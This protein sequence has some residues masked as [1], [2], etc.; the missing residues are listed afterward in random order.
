[1]DDRLNTPT[2]PSEGSHEQPQELAPD[3]E[4]DQGPSPAIEASMRIPS[5]PL[6]EWA[7]PQPAKPVAAEASRKRTLR[8][9]LLI[10]LSLTLAAFVLTAWVLVRVD[11]PSRTFSTGPQEIVRAQ[12][13]ALDQGQL[14]PAY[15]MFSARYR[16][17]VTFDVW[18]E[19]I[20]THWRMFHA[21]VLRAG[22]PARSGPVVTL[23][24]HLRGSD[25][26]EYR[27]RFVLISLE[28]RW[29]ID[30]VH[31]AEEADEQN[32]VRI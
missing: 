17:Q 25:D 7:G 31:W 30:D 6:P 15:D 4:M 20:I 18:H 14:R 22:E 27:A 28:G 5:G 1:M 11:S 23:E 24:I 12:L 9:R 21:E 19:L 8:R 29:W 10:L 3:P 16:Q 2:E 13:R 32:T 26:R